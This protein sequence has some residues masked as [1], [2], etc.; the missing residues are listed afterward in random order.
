MFGR[1]R[2]DPFLHYA[3]TRKLCLFHRMASHNSL[4]VGTIEGLANNRDGTM[5]LR[6]AVA[7]FDCPVAP[8]DGPMRRN[9]PSHNTSLVDPSCA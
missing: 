7:L 8:D 6:M 3:Q 9:S 5:N 1:L 4:N 2:D